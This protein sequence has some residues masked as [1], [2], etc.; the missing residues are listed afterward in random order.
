MAQ[1]RFSDIDFGFASAETEGAQR[2]ALLLEGFL[3][4]RGVRDKV[5]RGPDFLCLGYKGSGKSAISEHLRLV[6]ETQSDLFVRRMFLADFPFSDFANILRG[7]QDVKSRYPATWQWLLFLQILDSLASDQGATSTDP[8]SFANTIET[9]KRYALLPTP[10]LHEIVLKSSERGFRIS[11]AN[12]IEGAA[13][14]TLAATADLNFLTFVEILRRSALSIRSDS[15]H[16]LVIDG[17]DD[18]LLR[19][20]VQY[21]ALASLVV[22]VSRLNAALREGG[23]PAKIV[24][25]CRS[26]IYDRLPG[27]NLNKF[28]QDSAVELHWYSDPAHPERSEL[29]ALANAKA[30]VSDNRLGD[31]FNAFLPLTVKVGTR[32]TPV[33]TFLLDRTRHLPR[34]FLQLLKAIQT[35]SD[36]HKGRLTWEMMNAGTRLYSQRY[37]VAEIRDELAGHFTVDERDAG[38]N[39]I[40]KLAA[41]RFKAKDLEKAIDPTASL[42]VDRFLAALYDCGAIGTED[43][44]IYTYRYRNPHVPFDNQSTIVLHRALAPALN[45]GPLRAHS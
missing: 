15:T 10:S 34:D 42:D 5:L 39:A 37:F 20:P 44:G 7:S 21:E 38:L 11:L 1:L 31:V 25:L 33:R 18:I 29:V 36:R 22:E 23:T 6:A 40:A 14:G 30:R 17:L 43:A 8:A 26:D 2:P 9:L 19:E 12:T 13:K 16:L 27:P 45:I 32:E 4:L 41:P 28:R 35:A 3:D 24:L